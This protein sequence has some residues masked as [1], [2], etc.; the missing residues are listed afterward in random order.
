VAEYLGASKFVGR[1]AG[2]PIR[3]K[4]SA[5]STDEVAVHN[6]PTAIS[7]AGDPSD[8]NTRNETKAAADTSV[9]PTI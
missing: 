7:S 1:S 8:A 9:A 2:W 5:R 6:N 3:F 4:G